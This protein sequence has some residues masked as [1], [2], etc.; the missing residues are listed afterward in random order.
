MENGKFAMHAR[1]AVC[2]N[3]EP[4]ERSGCSWNTGGLTGYYGMQKKIHM[5][6]VSVS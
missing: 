4:G 5:I 2:M 6:I 1:A 3:A